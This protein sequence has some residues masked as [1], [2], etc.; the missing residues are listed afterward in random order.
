MTGTELTRRERAWRRVMWRREAYGERERILTARIVLWLSGQL[1]T[2]KTR[3]KLFQVVWDDDLATEENPN[4][5]HT[6]PS[7]DRVRLPCRASIRLL[8]TAMHLAWDH[9]DHFALDHSGCEVEARCTVR[10][11]RGWVHPRRSDEDE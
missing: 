6:V 10:R 7:P 4:P 3:Q 1:G 5:F 9:W 11:C 8:G 2:V